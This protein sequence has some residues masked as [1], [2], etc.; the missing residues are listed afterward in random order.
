M[1]Q[2]TPARFHLSLR[3]SRARFAETVAFYEALF[4]LPPSKRRPGYAKFEV[5]EPALNMTL[6]EV[7]EVVLNEV[8]H[9]GLQVWST[10]EL[11]A[12]R[13]RVEAAGLR[14]AFEEEQTECCY[15]AQDKF[16]LVDPEGRKVE[17]FLVLHDVEHFGERPAADGADGADGA[18]GSA[19]CAPIVEEAPGAAAAEATSCCAPAA[20]APAP[21]AA[22]SSCC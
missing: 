4:G 21:A 12:A 6:N 1:T 5:P 2:P 10:D 7:E 18:S 14:V 9:L 3:A 17:F 19:C 11:A 13:A 20:A 8:D 22:K 16:W 15:A